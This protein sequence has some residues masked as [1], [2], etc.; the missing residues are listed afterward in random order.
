MET[1]AARTELVH[2][3]RNHTVK[4]LIMFGLSGRASD[5]LL[6]MRAL[7]KRA[8]KAKECT[9]DTIVKAA[10]GEVDK[11]STIIKEGRKQDKIE[12]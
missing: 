4:M 9:Y 2:K 11:I 10:V 8:K 12:K 1:T 7:G 3:V 5:H 6:V